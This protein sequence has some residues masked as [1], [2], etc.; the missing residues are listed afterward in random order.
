MLH[1]RLMSSTDNTPQVLTAAD[2]GELLGY[3]AD[4]VRRLVRNGRLP[5]PIDPTI[6]PKLWRWSRTM[7]DRYIETGIAA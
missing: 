4:T 5:A 3:R 2:V 1:C 6:N 7:V